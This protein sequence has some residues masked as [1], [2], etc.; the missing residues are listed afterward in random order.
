VLVHT[1][2]FGISLIGE[3]DTHQSVPA[4]ADAATIAVLAVSGEFKAVVAADA[5]RAVGTTCQ[6]P[7]LDRNGGIQK[8]HGFTLAG[9]A[10]MAGGEFLCA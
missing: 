3:L 8:L 6:S 7:A 1:V 5:R 4:H 9:P 10:G 2:T